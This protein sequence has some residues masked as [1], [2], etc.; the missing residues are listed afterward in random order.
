MKDIIIEGSIF[1]N[2]GFR[3]GKYSIVDNR[4]VESSADADYRGT[5]LKAPINFHTHIGDSFIGEEPEGTIPEIVGPSGFKVRKLESAPLSECKTSMKKSIKFMRDRGTAAFFDFR[6]SRKIRRDEAYKIKGIDEFL[7]TR[8][9][10]KEES[11]TVLEDSAGFGM[12]SLNDYD[13][14]WLLFLSKTAKRRGKI[15]A[16]H[17][18]E[19]VK[20]N[21]EDLLKLKPDFVV[22]CIE[23]DDYDTEILKKN[24]IPV[25]I[26]PRSNIFLGKRPDY[27]RFLDKGL[28]L[29]IGTDNAFLTEPDIWSE[30]EFLYRY[31]KANHR[32]SPEKILDMIT[33]DPRKVMDRMGLSLSKEVYILYSEEELSAYEIITRPNLY[34]RKILIADNG[35]DNLFSQKTLK[36]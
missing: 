8:P 31:Q 6:E 9:S 10:S 17:F 5:L 24:E 25:V 1:V 13:L 16:I 20:E 4:F 18:S 3:K 15:F 32:I 36:K 21:V 35:K 19:N 14:D 27:G 22:H 30:A 2:G 34:K 12:S 33:E 29:L 28:T 23:T 7:L 11:E 26:T